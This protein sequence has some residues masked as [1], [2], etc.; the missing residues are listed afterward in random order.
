MGDVRLARMSLTGWWRAV[1]SRTWASVFKL[2][3][4]SA[5]G[6][7]LLLCAVAPRGRGPGAWSWEGLVLGA[8]WRDT[9]RRHGASLKTTSVVG[10]AAG[11]SGVC[12]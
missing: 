8:W 9:V 5:K 12:S 10:R 3:P 6:H 4:H 1:L 2:T 11:V 7:T